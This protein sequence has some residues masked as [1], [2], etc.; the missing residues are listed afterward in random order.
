VT[1]RLPDAARPIDADCC[2]DTMPVPEGPAKMPTRLDRCPDHTPLVTVTSI[3]YNHARFLEQALESIRLQTF[4][5]FELLIFDD[6]STDASVAR[7]RRWIA[8]SG[9]RCTFIPHT[10]NRGVCA[11]LNE[12]LARARGKYFCGIST[13][14][15][16]MPEKLAH[17][18][19]MIERLPEA[20]GVVYSDAYQIDEAGH[21]LPD[22]YLH[23]HGVTMPPAGRLFRA[24]LKHCF[25]PAVT[26]LRRTAALRHVG[27]Y[28]ESLWYEDWDMWLR[29]SRHYEFA[30]SDYVSAKYRILPTSLVRTL[31]RWESPHRQWTDAR[32]LFKCIRSGQL[33][34]LETVPLRIRLVR[35]AF[36][37]H[38]CRDPRAFE[39]LKLATTA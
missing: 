17:Q 18:T 11:T 5:D 31:V 35:M 3:C 30:F 16:W 1:Q 8:D 36:R 38:R 34:R 19:A 37:L 22:N 32:I 4:H 23:A 24:M 27:G 25:I 2:Q 6:C 29:L 9:M 12:A 13:D 7:I 20:V 15:V 10:V 33:S 39:V 14:D 21:P 26:T 28:D